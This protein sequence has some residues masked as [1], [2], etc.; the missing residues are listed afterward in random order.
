MILS[1]VQKEEYKEEVLDQARQEIFGPERKSGLKRQLEEMALVFWQQGETDLAEAA[2]AS[3]MDLERESEALLPNPFLKQLIGSAVNRLS[4]EARQ[5]ADQE[6][7]SEVIHESGSG[8]ISPGG[9]W[10]QEREE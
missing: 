9:S 6:A 3:A 10:N 7:A 4:L 5:R 2:L 1:D 8:L